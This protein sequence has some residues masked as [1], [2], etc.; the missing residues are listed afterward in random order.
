MWEEWDR[1]VP[2]LSRFWTRFVIV[3]LL[4]IVIESTRGRIT[5]RSTSTIYDGEE[6]V[7]LSTF[8]YISR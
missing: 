3:L 6:E 5:S 1:K 8:A 7:T 4:V 2:L